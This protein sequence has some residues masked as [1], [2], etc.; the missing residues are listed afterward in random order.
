[1]KWILILISLA[2]VIAG[3]MLARTKQN[4]AVC[5]KA[6]V[7]FDI[8]PSRQFVTEASIL[9][10]LNSHHIEYKGKR[11]SEID[12]SKAET[13]LMKQPFIRKVD[14]YLD[15]KNEFVVSIY[16]RNPILRVYPRY[17]APYY[18]DEDGGK[19]P[20]SNLFSADVMVA[21]GNITPAVNSKLYT[22]A[23]HVHQSA[24]WGQF[25]EHIF[26]SD[27]GDLTFTT[28]IAGHVV[29]LGDTTRLEGK[30]TKLEG[31][32]NRALKNVGW[33]QFKEIHLEYKDQVICRK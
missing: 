30:L 3:L 15:L 11:G 25:I 29:V 28:Q 14:C 22:M 33:D 27:N 4:E 24:F 5:K 7:E 19:F 17:G 26:V 10:Y 12:L 1:M 32:Y 6:R 20:L 9:S 13:V 23:R 8:E 18:L 16:Q 31:F 2:V 21:S